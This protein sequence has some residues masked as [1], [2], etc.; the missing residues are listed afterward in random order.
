MKNP[1]PP[2]WLNCCRGCGYDLR[3]LNGNCPECGVPPIDQAPCQVMA[4]PKIVRQVS[5]SL[6]ASAAGFGLVG[7]AVVLLIAGRLPVNPWMLVIAAGIGLIAMSLLLLSDVRLCGLIRAVEDREALSRVC[8]MPVLVA[9]VVVH[10]AWLVVF[11]IEILWSSL[12]DG[13]ATAGWIVAE[14]AFLALTSV[15]FTRHATLVVAF[16]HRHPRLRIG[17]GLATVIRLTRHGWWAAPALWLVLNGGC[18]LG[19]LWCL[20]LAVSW[21]SLLFLNAQAAMAWSRCAKDLAP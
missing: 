20:W 21:V 15:L 7:P 5:V 11:A 19:L 8:G 6:F 10:G 14:T 4:S 13:V 3:N 18:V 12:G 17:Q 16:V 9:G 2:T 1:P